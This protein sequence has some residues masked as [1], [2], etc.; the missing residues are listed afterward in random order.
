[1]IKRLI[2]SDWKFTDFPGGFV[3]GGY[4]PAD[5]SYKT[6]D[7][8][9][10]YSIAKQRGEA[11]GGSMH[12]GYYPN[13]KAKY[14]KYLRL[15]EGK[16]YVL[17]IDGAYMCT[18][19]IL[20]EEHVACHPY[21]YSP[22]L[23]DLTPYKVDGINNKLVITTTPLNDSCR[24]YTGNG[25]FRDVFLWEGGD[26]RI[27]PWDL[28][29]ST[30]SIC[31]DGAKI[32][33]KYWVSAEEDAE[34]SVSFALS[35]GGNTVNTETRKLS[36]KGGQK[37]EDVFF[38]TVED[39]KLWDLENTN[40]Y[41]IRAEIVK[42]GETTDVAESSFGIRT[43]TADAENGL[44]LNGKSIKLRGGN[45]HQDHGVLGAASFPAAEERKVRLLKEAGFN[46]LRMAHNPPSLALLEVCDRLGMIVMDEA[47]DCWKKG[48]RDSDY[49]IFFREWWDRDISYMVQRERNHPC[50]F[51]YSI[52]NEIYEIDGTSK[53]Y[54]TSRMLSDEIRKYDDTRFVTSGIQKIF[55]RNRVPETNIDPDDYANY[56]KERFNS[57][58][59]AEINGV[60][61]GYEAPLD[62]IGC[63]YYYD[64]YDLD[65]EMYPGRVMWGS[66]TQAVL[67]Y[68]SW[69]KVKEHACV[70]G[71]FTWTAYDNMGE[72]GM[73]K[74]VWEKE[75]SMY[76]RDRQLGPY[77]YRNCYQGDLD[78]CGFRR[79]QSYFREAVW[80][81][82]TAPRI[83]VTHPK[84]FG[85]KPVGT[86]WHWYDVDETWTFDPQW[87]GKDVKVETYTDADKIVWYVNGELIGESV[88]EKAIA[89]INTVYKP[90]SITAVAFKNGEKCGEYTVNTV[91]KAAVIKVAPDKAE[92][93]ADNRDLCYFEVSVVDENGALVVSGEHELT[94]TVE[95]GEL[96]GIYS[97]NPSNED[98][99]T[100][101]V[102]HSF[103]G[104]ALAVVRTKTAGDVIVTVVAQGLKTGS[105]TVKAK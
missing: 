62:I 9:H 69:G 44:L 39:P 17:D 58:S 66:E 50:V 81:G 72:C 96:M 10:D 93:S 37:T 38:M 18:E 28:F 99:F 2:S 26:I 23:V 73:G 77:P 19:V 54:E 65:K 74:M 79:P 6:I 55:L 46:A 88:P 49:H 3:Y 82:N 68:D 27:E 47:F 97:G 4:T 92:L 40:M 89:T 13:R 1:M 52:G 22:Y 101:K 7:L 60:T 90:G 30:D 76:D 42:D 71:D 31:S 43:V 67:F 87:E 45:I 86:G 12:N 36:V 104:K 53:V 51:S 25:I 11:D 20:N 78:L 24:W 29:A 61:R 95:G 33:V 57:L 103:K 64:R 48:K 35:F 14:V 15:E 80:L 102:C 70:L 91:G 8:P 83:F 84:H 85:D 105:S 56:L 41:D 59:D 34:I 5:P 16:R 98:Q 94:C 63:N 21:G 75:E 100:S 32:R